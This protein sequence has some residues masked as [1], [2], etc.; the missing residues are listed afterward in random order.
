MQWEWSYILVIGTVVALLGFLK[1]PRSSYELIHPR[2]VVPG[3][4][5][6][7]TFGQALLRDSAKEDLG[8]LY[9]SARIEY[10]NA[11]LWYVILAM[12]CFF[13]G[14]AI[15]VGRW[16][17]EPFAKL[18][19]QI[20]VNPQ[21]LRKVG[22]MGTWGLLVF[23]TVM[24]GPRALGFTHIGPLVPM[25]ESLA[26]F[27]AIILAV[28]AVF[29]AVMLGVSWPEPGM[30]SVLTYA[31]MFMGLFINSMYTMPIMSRGVG[32]PV[33]VAAMAYSIRVRRFRLIVM[34]PAVL[35]VALC[36]HAGLL[37][38][39][40]YGRQSDVITYLSV[41]LQYSISDPLAVL[42]SGAGLNDCFT[43]LA[44]SMKAITRADVRPLTQV[45]WLIF[46]LPIP[47]W[48]SFMPDWT[49][50]LTL[51]IGGYGTWGYTVGM[52][53]DTFIHWGWFGPLWFILVGIAYRF[54]SELVFSPHALRS[55]GISIYSLVL[56]SG[57]YAIGSGVFNTYRAWVTGFTIPTVLVVLFLLLR[58]L[59]ANPTSDNDA[60]Q[61]PQQWHGVPREQAGGWM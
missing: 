18:E 32:L 24:V 11:S 42:R 57:Y 6:L 35:W 28:G 53:G 52:L 60:M 22:W 43:S 2:F 50:D 59:F 12:L 9:E 58:K 56:F 33:F 46:Q 37:G 15:P 31:G 36:A 41:L 10:G 29:N 39:S 47:H 27:V 44:M 54:I 25:S 16:I 61:D 8:R 20:Q 34:V 51:Y 17:S 19:T 45:D 13:L 38:R 49:L 7:A 3:I 1:W 4:I 23:F 14:M 55:G 5:W 48:F 21:R 40:L 26:K 30:R